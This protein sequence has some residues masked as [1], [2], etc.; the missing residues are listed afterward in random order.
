MSCSVTGVAFKTLSGWRNDSSLLNY[1]CWR[2]LSKDQRRKDVKKLALTAINAVDHRSAFSAFRNRK[3]KERSG[4]DE[5][6]KVSHTDA[7]LTELLDGFM[8]LNS[9][10]TTLRLHGQG[11]GVDGVRWSYHSTHHQ[12]VHR[13][14]YTC[15]IPVLTVHDSYIAPLEHELRL[16]RTMASACEK[17]L[18]IS[19]FNIKGEKLTPNKAVGMTLGPYAHDKR[20]SIDVIDNFRR[21]T[22]RVDGYLDRFRDWRAFQERYATA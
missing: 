12:K 10:D 1:L 14:T 4:H 21:N 8:E 15:R 17:E 16:E 20:F 5:E 11:R 6:P 3:N 9:P 7:L 2:E 19:D 13:R 18:G 22:V